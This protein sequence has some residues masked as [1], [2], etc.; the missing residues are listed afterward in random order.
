[1]VATHGVEPCWP[2][3]WELPPSESRRGCRGRNRTDK[4]WL[5]RPSWITNP[6]C[7]WPPRQELNLDNRLRRPVPASGRTRRWTPRSEL[8]RV[9]RLR[10]PVPASGWTRGRH[11]VRDSNS[12]RWTENPASLP[13][14]EPGIGAPGET[15][16]HN[17]LDRSQLLSSLSYEGTETWEGVAPSTTGLQPAFR[18]SRSRSVVISAGP[19]ARRGRRH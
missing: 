10:R 14:D 15:Q 9:N 12:C 11:P 19:A 13:L 17:L 7:A 3:L 4:A 5:M 18:S 2:A 16:T 1:M 8:N 6:P